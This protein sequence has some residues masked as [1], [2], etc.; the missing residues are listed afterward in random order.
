MKNTSELQNKFQRLTQNLIYSNY[1]TAKQYHRI[2]FKKKYPNL[3]AGR[4]KPILIY[5]MGK[6]GSSTI[7]NSLKESALDVP[8][9]HLH[10]LT[11]KNL[12]ELDEILKRAYPTARYIADHL[13]AGEFLH[14]L[15]HQEPTDGKWK[16]ITL[17]REPI[18]RN[19]SSFMQDLNVR[20]PDFG[21]T[22]KLNSWE[23]NKL[24]DTI[25]DFFMEKHDHFLPLNWFDNELKKV[26][27]VDIF[28]TDFEREKGY[29]IYQSDK[30]EVLL[31]KLEKLNICG[32]DTIS[33]FLGMDNLELKN[34]N[35]GQQKV[36]KDVYKTIL[37]QI[38]FPATFLDKFYQSNFTKHFYSTD[39]IEEF[40]KKWQR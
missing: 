28:S 39:E 40:R 10:E 9:F 16:V 24:A 4:K 36:Y 21:F 2:A 17:V 20:N 26:F 11:K 1:W 27:D 37:R 15:V 30:A 5:Q 25:V 19:I 29:K 33:Q 7:Y 3:G 22:E 8:V 32:Q 35:V 38:T 12:I 31:I 6:V 14:D 18:A 13:I 23:T 34:Q